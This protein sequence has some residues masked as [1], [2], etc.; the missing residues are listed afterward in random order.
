MDEHGALARCLAVLSEHGLNLTRIES[1]PRPNSPWRYII[2]LEFVGNA[3][4]PQVQDA[5]AAVTEKVEYLR[6]LGSYPMRVRPSESE[7]QPA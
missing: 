2:V 7:D 4:D 5:V 6:M 1:R 3:A